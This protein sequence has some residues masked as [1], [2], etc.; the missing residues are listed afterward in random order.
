MERYRNR[1]SHKNSVP[2]ELFLLKKAFKPGQAAETRLEDGPEGRRAW[3]SKSLRAFMGRVGRFRRPSVLDLGR[4]NGGNIFFLG[5][6]GCRVCVNDFL[7][8]RSELLMPAGA[9]AAGEP[10]LGDSADDA[11]RK[12]LAGLEYAPAS[13]RGVICWDSLERIPPAWAKQLLKRLHGMLDAGGV[14]LSFFGSAK[15]GE[16]GSHKGF[17]ILDHDHVEPIPA[18]SEHPGRHGY[19]NAE[20]MDVFAGYKVLDFCLLKGGYREILVQKGGEA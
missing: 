3:V 9:G 14:I 10:D 6:Q 15:P 8:E 17:R 5:S 7:R 1:Y 16:A 20:I 2:N 12:I 4:V 19:K 18:A 11:W 13:L